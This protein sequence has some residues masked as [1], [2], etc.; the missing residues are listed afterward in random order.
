MWFAS[1]WIFTLNLPWQLGA[2]FFLEHLHDA[3]AASNTLSWRWVA[4]LQTKGKNYLAKSWNIEKYTN[5]KYSDVKLNENSQPLTEY[6]EYKTEEDLQYN[7][8]SKYKYLIMFD[9]D[10]NINLNKELFSNYEEIYLVLLENENRTIKINK[11]VLDFKKNIIENFEKKIQ[12]SIII[13]VSELQM[14]MSNEKN[15]D[16][17]YPFVGENLDFIIK[18]KKKYNLNLHFL[19]NKND[20]YCKKFSKKG[21][22][23]FKKNIPQIIST[24]KLC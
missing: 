6:Y 22:F 14:K 2:K 4:G 9:N 1:I 5:N 3:D 20:V 12:N 10:L 19:H 11:N 16:I 13:S 21:F 7:F 8:K 23:N 17:I 18:T 15:F 24:L